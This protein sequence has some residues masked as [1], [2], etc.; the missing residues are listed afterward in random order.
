MIKKPVFAVAIVSA[1][2]RPTG[3]IRY[4]CENRIESGEELVFVLL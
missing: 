1:S 2:N 4:A 3:F